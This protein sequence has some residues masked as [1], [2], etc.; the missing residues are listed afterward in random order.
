M[1]FL[2]TSCYIKLQRAN[3]CSYIGTEEDDSNEQ[4]EDKTHLPRWK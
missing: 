1:T 3:F 2:F 4:A